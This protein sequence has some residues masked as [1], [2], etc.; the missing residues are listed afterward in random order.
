MKKTLLLVLSFCAT[1]LVTM[2]KQQFTKPESPEVEQQKKDKKENWFDE[3]LQFFQFHQGIRTADDQPH[4]LYKPGYKTIELN[5]AQ[6]RAQAFKFARTERTN[7]VIEFKERGPSNVP[8]RTRTILVL[9]GDPN[10][11]TWIAGS[12]TGGIWKTTNG[13]TTWTEKSADFPVYPISS[14]AM[15]ASDPNT[16]YAGTGEF[17]SSIY[18]AVGDGIF[19]S[20]DQ[21]ETWTQLSSTSGN[22]NFSIVTRVIVNPTNVNILLASTAPSN[23]ST[24]QTSKI[25]RSTDGGNSWTE[26]Y[27]NTRGVEQLIASP[28]DFNVQYAAINGIGVAKSI[29]GGVTWNLSNTGMATT[30][31][32]ELGVSPA[33]TNRLYASC[34]GTRSGNGSDLYMSSDAAQ[35]WT[36]VDVRF[37]NAVLD[38]LNGQGIYDN[39]VLCDPFNQDIV[40]FGG[41]DT[42]RSTIESGTTTIDDYKLTETDTQGFLTLI[43]FN[44]PRYFADERLQVGSASNRRTVEIRFGSGRTQNAH[45]FLTPVNAT[46]GVPTTQ[47]TYTDYVEVPLQAWDVTIPAFPKQLMVSFRD[48]SRNGKLDFLL[49]NFDPATPEANS[50]EYLYVHSAD[51]NSATPLFTANSTGG[52]ETQL[53][54]GIFP[55]LPPGRTWT[56][57]ALPNSIFK[58]EYTGLSKQNATTVTVSDSRSQYDRKNVQSQVNQAA[59]GIHADNHFSAA[60]ITSVQNKTYKIL[61][62]TDGGTFVSKN[63]TTP[64]IIDGDWTFTGNGFNTSQ[65][66]GADKKPGADEYIGGLQDNGTRISTVG[67]SASKTTNYQYAIGGDGFEVLWHSI[68]GNK[69][70]GSLYNNRFFRSTNGGR[71]WSPAF[72]GFTLVGGSPDPDKYPFVSKLANSRN[73]PDVIYSVG[74]DG[75]WKSSNF[76]GLWT[77]TPITNKWGTANTFFDVEVSR[78]NANIVW[79]GAGMTNVRNLHVSTNGGASFTATNNYTAATLGF[80]TKLASHPTHPN[81][82]YALF[83]FYGKPKIL[84]TTDLGQNWTDISGFGTGSVSTNGFPDVATY[85]LYVMPDNPNIIWAGTEIGIVESKNNGATWALLNDFP[86]VSVWD[87]KGQDNQIVIATHGRGIWTAN[88]TNNQNPIQK[89]QLLSMGTCP[90]QDLAIRFQLVSSYDSLQVFIRGQR[91]GKINARAIGIY[92]LNVRNV[93]P[94][95]NIEVSFIGFKDGYPFQSTAFFGNHFP[96]YT[97]YTKEYSNLMTASTDFAISPLGGYTI[98]TFG[99]SN[100]SL[101]SIHPYPNNS[102]STAMLLQPII[103][104]STNTNFFY[105]DVAIIQPSPDVNFGQP[106]FKDFVVVEATKN[107]LDWI[108]LKDG[109]NASTNAAWQAAFTDNQPDTPTMLVDHSID[110]KPKFATNDTL[111]FRFRLKANADQ[112]TGWG[113]SIDNL[114]IQQAPT[115]IELTKTVRDI[116]LFPNPTNGKVK[117]QFMLLEESTVS[118]ETIDAKGS[119]VGFPLTE[120]FLEGRHEKEIDL[121]GQSIGLYYIKVKTRGETKVIKVIKK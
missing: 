43:Q 67:E 65:F 75:I 28:A 115:G 118:I 53:A 87:M 31:R 74:S 78:A 47:Y 85:C 34:E 84:R 91:I 3:P 24:G 96:L 58:I 44:N 18:S 8:G 37:D 98:S 121:I 59:G 45:R 66:Y 40:Y 99:T 42:F 57:N 52:H 10:Q 50:R 21:G 14:L 51:Y 80:I 56:P 62:T 69:I 39:H 27:Q 26:V 15:S 25:M 112:I 70:I 29:D 7:G 33:N 111:L 4:P 101:Q 11:N 86:N 19:K 92:D 20:S 76:G 64:G 79:G 107:G 113:W 119:V 89:P 73:V 116:T 120:K 114:F 32:V 6:N 2:Q 88:M 106:G 12:A 49:Q 93:P 54:Y 22:Q 35:T 103:V 71:N 46:S 16:V 30:G 48:Q 104:A 38:F 55:A 90:N 17:V 102:E 13:G 108:P 94:G 109:Y 36:L 105:Q 1:I 82:A 9:P 83:S 63:S 110:I 97:R 72:S 5:A 23:L 68:D 41:V 77:L 60:I 100:Q 117:L 95:M 81:T 61:L